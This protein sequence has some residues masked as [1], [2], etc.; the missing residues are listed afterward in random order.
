MS[1]SYNFAESSAGDYLIEPSSHFTYVC[2]DGTPKSLYATVEDVAEV[3]LSG[4]LTV[5]RVHDKRAAYPGCTADNRLVLAAA[6]S[7]AEEYAN[8]A[9]SYLK[10]KSSVTPRYKLWF[11]H[12]TDA[13]KRIVQTKFLLIAST[14]FSGFTY[15]CNCLRNS[16][17]PDWSA[18]VGAYVFQSWCKSVTDKSLDQILINSGLSTSALSSGQSLKPV[19]I[20]RLEHLS[21]SLPTSSSTAAPTT[22]ITAGLKP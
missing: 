6:A 13:R 15:N 1:A 16:E 8:E 3:K 4:N 20:P 21:T 10:S 7:R 17:H 5:S 2:A 19:P 14:G 11:G 18:Y 12:Y 22:S 9:Y